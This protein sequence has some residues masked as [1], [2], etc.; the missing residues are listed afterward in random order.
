[1]NWKCKLR[2][3]A[4]TLDKIEGEEGV[5]LILSLV[6]KDEKMFS[7]HWEGDIFHPLCQG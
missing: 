2:N 3:T 4:K 6:Q 7:S 5:T 1:M